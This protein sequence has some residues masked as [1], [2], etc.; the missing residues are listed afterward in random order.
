MSTPV[1]ALV[2]LVWA[3]LGCG[4]LERVIGADA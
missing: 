1:L 4:E 2:H 3:P